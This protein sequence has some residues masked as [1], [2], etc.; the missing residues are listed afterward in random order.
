MQSFHL[1]M[2]EF[3]VPPLKLDWVF[4]QSGGLTKKSGF[5]P[6]VDKNSCPVLVGTQAW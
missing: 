2:C 5:V 1:A 4:K 6:V 3:S